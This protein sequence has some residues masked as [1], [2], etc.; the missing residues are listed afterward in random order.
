MAEVEWFNWSDLQARTLGPGTEFRAVSGE[1]LMVARY[2]LKRGA[3]VA[4]HHHAQEQIICVLAGRIDFEANGVRR[5]LGP[6]DVA[7]LAPDASHGGTILD[8]AE[9]IEVFSPPRTDLL[10]PTTLLEPADSSRR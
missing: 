8:D 7:R 5:V 3:V 10:R 4:Q 9:T 2:W 6:G 1:N